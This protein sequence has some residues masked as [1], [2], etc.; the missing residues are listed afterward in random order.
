MTGTLLLLLLA[1]DG[2][3]SFDAGAPPSFDGPLYA[4]CP[5]A[6]PLEPLD[7]GWYLPRA[8]GERLSCLMATCESDRSRREKESA[9]AAPPLWWVWMTTA[10]VAAGVAGFTIGRYTAPSAP[11]TS[12]SGP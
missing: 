6:P 11:A 8:R 7:G 2:G 1:A 9:V 12:S 10:A 3:V 5:D 4:T